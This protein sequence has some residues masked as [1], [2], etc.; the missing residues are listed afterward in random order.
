M[1][2]ETDKAESILIIDDDD[3]MRNVAK[4]YLQKKGYRV[5]AAATGLQGLNQ[6]RR[7]Q[8]DLVLLDLTL[9]EMGGL[10]VLG[11]IAKESPDTPV[12]IIS[13]TGEISQAVKSF[14]LGA[15]D[16]ITKPINMT[17]LEYTLYRSLNHARLVKKTKARQVY[18][19]QWAKELEKRT[20]ELDNPRAKLIK[21]VH[22]HEE[23]HRQLKIMKAAASESDDA[24]VITNAEGHP[25]FTN[26]AFTRAF[27]HTPES[28]DKN[29]AVNLFVDEQIRLAIDDLGSYSGEAWLKPAKGPDFTAKVR[30]RIVFDENTEIIG[31]LFIFSLTTRT[32][33]P[34]HPGND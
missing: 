34:I 8:P 28:L 5:F 29:G 23:T 33:N 3:P 21:E 31:M 10:E 12:V 13:G 30:V 16:F 25:V 32:K 17:T 18:L 14:K 9:P 26:Q 27:R 4:K 24:I 20:T 1:A 11:I 6:F 7:E 15:C 22:D 19:D 2:E